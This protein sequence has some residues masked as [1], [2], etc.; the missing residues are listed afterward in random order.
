LVIVELL[1][2]LIDQESLGFE[3]AYN[4]IISQMFS[5]TLYNLKQQLMPIDILEKLLPRHLELIYLINFHMIEKLKVD[6]PDQGDRYQRMSLI[7]ES[8]PKSVRME[9]L[10]LHTCAKIDNANESEI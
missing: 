9:N 3:R 2:I 8:H 10:I 1:R 6:Y 4:G 5:C 7:E